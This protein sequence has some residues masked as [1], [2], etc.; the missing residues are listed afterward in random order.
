MENGFIQLP[1]TDT[2]SISLYTT[3]E[4]GET[5]V[6]GGFKTIYEN[7][8]KNSVPI[9]GDIPLI[10]NLFSYKEKLQKERRIL[11]I[12]SASIIKDNDN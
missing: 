12:V 5:M 9:L 6:I 2:R 10:G 8:T 7:G 1:K 11:F 4:N 3:L